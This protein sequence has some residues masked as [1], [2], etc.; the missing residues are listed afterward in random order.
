MKS[1]KFFICLI[2]IGCLSA[3]IQSCMITGVKG[4][5]VVT[6][7]NRSIGPF[8]EIQSYISANIILVKSDS[9][10]LKLEGEDN[11]LP[12]IGTSVENGRLVIDADKSFSSNKAVKIYVPFKEL[13]GISLYGSGDV[14][15]ESPVAG[16]TL[17]IKISGSG[18]VK[19]ALFVKSLRTKISGSG[20]MN[21]AGRV[22]THD[23]KI[24][25]SGKIKALDLL[26]LHTSAHISGS[27]TCFVSASDEL[28]AS[29]SGSG[30]ILYKNPPAKLHKS[31]SGSGNIKQ[32][33]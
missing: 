28:D 19:L 9:D 2:L 24:S 32:I 33:N 8:R 23:I 30:D 17:D 25:G 27:G 6:S 7:V 13:D 26:S 21:L 10:Q 3:S 29:I 14:T 31:V 12:L 22:E 4:S 16:E 1:V 18:D 5:G 15:S 20:N 11:I